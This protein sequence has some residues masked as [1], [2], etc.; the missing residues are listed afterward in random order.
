MYAGFECVHQ[1]TGP[2]SHVGH[3]EETI[4]RQVRQTATKR[5][6]RPQVVLTRLE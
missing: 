3:S 4:E 1:T 2:D 6:K 5:K